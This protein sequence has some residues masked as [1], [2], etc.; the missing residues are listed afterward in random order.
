MNNIKIELRDNFKVNQPMTTKGW[1]FG[2]YVDSIGAGEHKVPHAVILTEHGEFELV[3]FYSIKASESNNK[4]M[5]RMQ[6][7]APLITSHE[8][9]NRF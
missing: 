4:Q 3:P 6:T 7:A 2:H 5:Q 9:K 8:T 1:K